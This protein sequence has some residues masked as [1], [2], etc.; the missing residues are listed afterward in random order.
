MTDNVFFTADHHFG[1]KRIIGYSGREFA[2]T[3]EMDETM[4][5]SWNGIVGLHDRVYHLGDFSFHKPDRTLNILCRLNGVKWLIQGNHDRLGDD[6]K[7]HFQWVKDYHEL[8]LGSRKIIL[9]HYPFDTWRASHHGSWHLHGHSHGSLTT[10]RGGRLDIGVDC[11]F[12]ML[13]EYRPFHFDEIT[14]ELQNTTYKP[15]DHHG[16]R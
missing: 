4:I 8:K 3:D 14:S 9:C 7:Q 16:R 1:H 15:V 10:T 5:R 11:A 6:V 13:G 2:T 12:R